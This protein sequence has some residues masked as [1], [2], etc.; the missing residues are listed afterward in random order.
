M[1]G[2]KKTVLFAAGGTGGHIYPA[3]STAKKL[4]KRNVECI[5]VGTPAGIENKIIPKNGFKIFHINITGFNRV[6]LKKKNCI[7]NFNAI[8]I[9]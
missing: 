5:F 4:S 8:F 7:L 3:L 1:K 6:G 9:I 2:S